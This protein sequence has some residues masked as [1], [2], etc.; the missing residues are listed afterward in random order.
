MLTQPSSHLASGQAALAAADWTGAKA[1][2]QAALNEHNSPEAHD[3]LGVALWWLNDIGAS[4][5]QRAAAYLGY[6]QRGDDRQA[7]LIAVWLARE[8]VFLNAN[9]SAMNG[10]FERAERLLSGVTPG[11]EH[12]WLALFRASMMAPP[13]DLEQIAFDTAALARQFRDSDLEVA[14]LAFGGL[15]RVAQGRVDQGMNGLDEA[16]AA[17]TGGEVGNFMIISEVFC[18][19]LSACELSG[20]WVRTEHWCRAASDYARRYNCS[21]LSAYCR[22]TYGGLLTAIGRWREAETELTEAIRAF[23]GGHRGLRVHAVLKLADLRVSQGRLEEAEVL[24]RGFEDQSDATL[25]LARLYLARQEPKLARAVLEQALTALPT[26][27]VGQAPLLWLWVQVSLALGDLEAARTAAEQLGALARQAHSDMLL[28]QADLAQG[29]ITRYADEAEAA[30]YFRSALDHLRQ[31]EQSVLASRAKLELARSLKESDPPAALTW[32]RAAL[33]T[34]E[35]MGAT[36]EADEAAKVLRAL[37]A[38]GRVSVRQQTPLT[39]REAEVLALLGRGLTNR[40]IAKRLVIS[41]KTVEHHVG[42]I[43]DK[44]GLRNRAEAAAY[45]AQNPVPENRGDE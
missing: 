8:Q 35:R 27:T 23:E 19:T 16:M 30:R 42:Q 29:H 14:A 7:A 45:V 24:L 13:R 18:V 28:A 11:V 43:L 36:G 25:P 3:R 1:A 32:A 44:L 17:A 20:D 31:Y 10:W 22:T 37:G 9:A 39:P 26:P 6:R 4:H 33:A 34:F 40:E 15:A 38:A 2:F 12:G 5:E 21:F 41:A